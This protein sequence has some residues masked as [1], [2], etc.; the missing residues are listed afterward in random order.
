[1]F[2]A[3]PNGKNMNSKICK[4]GMLQV[5]PITC[6]TSFCT[7]SSIMSSL[8]CLPS[9]PYFSTG[10][11]EFDVDVSPFFLFKNVVR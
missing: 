5:I 3:N 4:N 9:C 8:T 2:V 6:P 1:M 10:N 11:I 7:R